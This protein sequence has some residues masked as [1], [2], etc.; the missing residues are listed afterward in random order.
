[1]WDF[2][3]PHPCH[4]RAGGGPEPPSKHWSCL[5]LR[6]GEILFV[7]LGP[8]LR[9]GDKSGEGGDVY[10]PLFKVSDAVTHAPTNFAIDLLSWAGY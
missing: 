6:G 10:C 4:P 1:M 2:L 7:A 8:R 5:A 3:V 9:G